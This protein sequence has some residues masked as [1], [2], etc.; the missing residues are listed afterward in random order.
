MTLAHRRSPRARRSARLLAVLLAAC[1]LAAG[2]LAAAAPATA[3]LT[4][5]VGGTISYA[6]PGSSAP[7]TRVRL[8]PV[9]GSQPASGGAYT[10][11]SSGGSWSVAGVASGRYRILFEATS[12]DNGAN[13]PIW[14]GGTP[15]EDSAQ[16]V[17]VAGN[18]TG[19]TVSQPA[20]GSISGTVTGPFDPAT[21]QAYLLNPS[22]GLFERAVGYGSANTSGTGNYTI[23][24]LAAGEYVVRF[25]D[26]T[27]DSPRFSTQYYN[28]AT[29][30]WDSQTVTVAAGQA[31][32]GIN[33]SVSTWGWGWGR[34]DGADRF[35]TSANVS[36]AIYAPGASTGNGPIVHVASGLNFPDALSASAAAAAVGGPLLLTHPNVV[37]DAIN[38][39]LVRLKPSKIVVVG[40]TSS[41]SDDV[42]AQLAKLTPSISRISGEDRYAT[43]RAVVAS[44]PAAT[45]TTV[46]VATGANFPDALVAG[47]A[48]GYQYGPLLLVNGAAD[49]LDSASAASITALSPKRIYIVGGVN[50][51]SAG[52]QSDLE[53][54]AVPQVLRL[55]GADRFGTAQAVNAAVFP[56]ADDAFIASGLGFAD[57]LSISAAA[58]MLG[59]PLLLAVPDCIPYGEVADA[60]LRGVAN[61]FSVGG[62]SVLSDAVAADLTLCPGGAATN[63]AAGALSD[64]HPAPATPVPAPRDGAHTGG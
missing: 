59:S 3:A 43:S 28:G 50:S 5:V 14:Y 24:G 49:G 21:L 62:S 15:F 63:G 64:V 35:A 10:T 2:S 52:I 7:T 39:E 61:Y 48:A 47:S 30:L 1:A 51:V 60:T 44:F 55:A 23:R 40:G 17:T 25:A 9:T 18:V 4:S 16:V 26:R 54:L 29:S 11:L 33:G 53:K 13:A 36:S 34:I 27:G 6:V 31:V 12:S 37:P 41:V 46:F 56:F 8:Y 20:A 45:A 32:T 38:A 19:L 58:G 22:T 42:Y 57:A